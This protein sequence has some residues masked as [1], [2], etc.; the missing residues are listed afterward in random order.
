MNQNLVLNSK[1]IMSHETQKSYIL[2][3]KNYAKIYKYQ[4]HKSHKVIK[5][6]C[7][8][9]VLSPS[10]DYKLFYYIAPTMIEILNGKENI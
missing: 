8:L 7:L 10:L 6:M 5:I 1:E 2:L 3:T 4:H 9:E